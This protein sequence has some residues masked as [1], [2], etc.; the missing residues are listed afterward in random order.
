[1][2]KGRILFGRI[3]VPDPTDRY[4]LDNP[5]GDQD[6]TTHYEPVT[7]GQSRRLAWSLLVAGVGDTGTAA[8][9]GE[10]LVCKGP[11]AAKAES[12]LG[13]DPV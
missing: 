9:S 1:M 3:D 12:V 5:H 8:G 6:N 11:A 2:K 4:V 10:P 7:S 13:W